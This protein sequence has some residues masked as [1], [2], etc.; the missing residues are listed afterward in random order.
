[1]YSYTGRSYEFKRNI[2]VIN[3]GSTALQPNIYVHGSI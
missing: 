1:M 2:D 3:H